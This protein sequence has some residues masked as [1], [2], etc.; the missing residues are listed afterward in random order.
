MKP[1]AFTILCLLAFAARARSQITVERVFQVNQN[2]PDNGHYLDVRNFDSGFATITDVDVGLELEGAAG[3]SMR[4]GDYYVSLTHGTASEEERVAV[5]LNRPRMTDTALFGSPLSSANIIFDDSGGAQNVFNI[6][7]ATGTYQADGRLGVDPYAPPVPYNPGDVTHGLAALNGNV[8]GETWH[9]LIADTRQGAAGR[10]TRWTLRTTGTSAETGLVDPGAGGA[11]AD[12]ITAPAGQ[13]DLKAVLAVSGSGNDGITARISERL[14]LSGGL[15]GSGQ[16]FKTG[17]GTLSVGGT[18]AGGGGPAAFTGSI[19]VNAGELEVASGSA[20]GV[21]TMVSLAGSNVT[22]RLATEDVIVSNMVISGGTTAT[23]RGE[24]TLAGNISG[25]GGIRKLDGG[26]VILTGENTYSGPT[27]VEAGSLVVN[28][29]LASSV[30]VGLNARLEGSGEISGDVLISGEISPGNSLGSHIGSLGVGDLVLDSGSTFTYAMNTTTLHGSLIHSEGGLGIEW[31]ASLV[32]SGDLS[33]L[34]AYGS[35]LTLISYVDG[36]DGGL[37]SVDGTP[38]TDGGV[39]AIGG[40]SWLF[41]YA[42]SSGGGNFASDQGG[43]TKFVTIT[44]VP[45]PGI[46][47]IFNL[48]L[49]GWLARRRR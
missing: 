22:L 16:L 27:M 1:H 31:G 41:N 45:E 2:V 42:D 47:L 36:W 46:L 21:G 44:S 23:I 19:V 11:I 17:A 48:A 26:D 29:G 14:V 20:F 13:R 9:L 24:G 30:E 49:V 7:T 25:L 10:L 32:F 34:A 37:F 38:V 12:D 43:A 18:S 39:L 3:N 6:A 35:K 28:G 5:L 15:S 33:A 8:V 40:N 4:L